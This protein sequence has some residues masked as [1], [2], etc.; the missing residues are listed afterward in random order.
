MT[1]RTYVLALSL[2]ATAVLG[3]LLLW[4]ETSDD[5]ARGISVAAIDPRP[6]PAT[7]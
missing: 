1:A 2:G 7:K 4:V 3:A 6:G 5:T